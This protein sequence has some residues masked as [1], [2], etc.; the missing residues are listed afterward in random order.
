[1]TL[2]NAR[3]A[4][5][6][7]LEA[8]AFEGQRQRALRRAGRYALVWPEEA[9]TLLG[10]GRPLTEFDAVGPWIARRIEAWFETPPEEEASSPLTSGFITYPVA[11]DVLASDPSWKDDLRGDLQMHSTY[12]DGSVSIAEMA[13]GAASLGYEYIAITDHSKGLRIAGG[14]DEER[15][16]QQ[17]VEIAGVNLQLDDLDAGLTVLRS[18]ELNLGRAGE[19]DMDPGALAE[20]DIVV[21]SFHSRLRVDEDQTERCLAAMTNPDVQIIGHPTGRMF[22]VRRGVRADWPRVMEE[23]RR[24]GKVLEV[25]AQPNRQDLSVEMLRVAREVGVMLSIGTDAHSVGELYNVDLALASLALAGIPRSQV[26]NLL[27]LEGLLALVEESRSRGAVRR[28]E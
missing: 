28:S 7:Y 14:I 5:L 19:G 1:M 10:S 11:R 15:L 25:N 3:L 18:I 13:G 27:P 22:G 2:T 20:L 12:S 8:A 6:L 4:E 24:R 26:V 21:G 9:S 17:L 16:G 23:A